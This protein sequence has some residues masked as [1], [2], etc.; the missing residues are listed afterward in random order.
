MTVTPSVLRTYTG[1]YFN[2]LE[3][4]PEQIDIEDIAQGLSNICRYSGQCEFYSVAQHSVYVA[5][6]LPSQKRL[7]GLLHDAPEAYLGDVVAPL[8]VL[9]QYDFYRTIEN[10]LMYEIYTKYGV[11]ASHDPEIKECDLAV[12]SSERHAFGR[13]DTDPTF[14]I[15]PW[16]PK[17]AKAIFLEDFRTFYG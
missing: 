6:L 1:R 5:W 4:D 9:E 7:K 15:I 14:D 10:D 2:P 12:A 16:T 17:E 13:G 11:D 3:P 8:K